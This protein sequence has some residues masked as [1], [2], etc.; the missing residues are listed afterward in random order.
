M[1][2]AHIALALSTLRLIFAQ[3]SERV[4]ERREIAK[5]SARDMRDLAIPS[6]IVEDECRRWPWQ[7]MSDGWDALAATRSDLVAPHPASAIG[8]IAANE[9][10]FHPDADL[11]GGRISSSRGDGED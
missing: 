11:C 7:T 2:N 9:G 1:R 3:W 5:M 10:A 8:H 4:A 6:D